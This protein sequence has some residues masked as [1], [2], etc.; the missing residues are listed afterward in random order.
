MLPRHEHHLHLSSK[1]AGGA[2]ERALVTLRELNRGRAWGA[3]SGPAARPRPLRRPSP[4]ERASPVTRVT[5]ARTAE[6]WRRAL[7]AG[8]SQPAYGNHTLRPTATAAEDTG[9]TSLAA[10]ARWEGGTGTHGRGA[11]MRA[12]VCTGSASPRRLHSAPPHRGRRAARGR[13]RP[14]VASAS[15]RRSTPRAT[16][17]APGRGREL[18][19]VCAAR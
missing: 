8:R 7:R 15:A 13:D 17:R 11:G 9:G 19:A 5:R 12:E 10:T 14:R 3:A 6:R 2:A 16:L 18:S 1:N 4:V